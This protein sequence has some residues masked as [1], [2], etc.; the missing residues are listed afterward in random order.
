MLFLITEELAIPYLLWF[1]LKKK[2][3]EVWLHAYETTIHQSWHEVEVSNCFDKI[4][5]IFQLFINAKCKG[6]FVLRSC[7]ISGDLWN[8]R[9]IE[10]HIFLYFLFCF[11]LW[12][13]QY[14]FFFLQPFIMMTVIFLIASIR[15]VI[16]LTWT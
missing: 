2:G 11:S 16:L 5:Y 10:N 4:L 15:L 12:L 13:L 3:D 7:D 8:L 6:A 1:D 14:D 9:K